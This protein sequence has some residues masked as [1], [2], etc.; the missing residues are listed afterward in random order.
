MMRLK[1]AAAAI[2]RHIESWLEKLLMERVSRESLKLMHRGSIT[3]RAD[4]A[5]WI[6]DSH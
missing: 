4:V 2:K 1:M 5:R 6:A 3:T